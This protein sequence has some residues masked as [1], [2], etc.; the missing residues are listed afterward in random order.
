MSRSKLPVSGVAAGDTQEPGLLEKLLGSKKKAVENENI[1]LILNPVPYDPEVD[2]GKEEALIE[3]EHYKDEAPKLELKPQQVEL[4][5]FIE[6][7]DSFLPES[8]NPV[9]AFRSIAGDLAQAKEIVRGALVKGDEY[10]EKAEN[11]ITEKY[12]G[13]KNAIKQD[14]PKTAK[15]LK[16]TRDQLID[17]NNKA[18]KFN[19]EF[20]S[21]NPIGKYFKWHR[22]QTTK[23]IIYAFDKIDKFNNFLLEGID[24]KP[25]EKGSRTGKLL[26]ETIEFS[27]AGRAV[28]SFSKIPA[29]VT[30]SRGANALDLAEETGAY[31]AKVNKVPYNPRRMEQLLQQNNPTATITS[32]TLPK[33]NQTNASL[34]KDV[35][36]KTGIIFDNRGFPIF[37]KHTVFDTKISIDIVQKYDTSKMNLPIKKAKN[38]ASDNHM[39][40]ATRDLREKIKQGVVDKNKFTSEQLDK[41]I[42]GKASISELTWHH[43]QDTG[44]MQLVPRNLHDQ[45]GHVGGMNLWYQK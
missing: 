45:V 12:T 29:K 34:A 24:I 6:D 27:G 25:G 1:P 9:A 3:N 39:R 28:S 30:V 32:N 21:T 42:K 14:Y 2:K 10:I 40:A 33:V 4:P 41:I 43:H 37:D 17:F 11:F 8:Y 19:E 5:R 7:G 36:K 35:H 26:F 22:E 31:F 15:V 20:E 38:I 13:L 23:P 18:N 16:E 44:R